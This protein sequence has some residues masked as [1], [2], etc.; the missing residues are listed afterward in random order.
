MG[1]LFKISNTGGDKYKTPNI[2]NCFECCV[3]IS[4]PI[5]SCH[6][7]GLVDHDAPEPWLGG[8]TLE[9]GG[10]CSTFMKLLPEPG[11]GAVHS[12]VGVPISGVRIIDGQHMK[13]GTLNPRQGRMAYYANATEKKILDRSFILEWAVNA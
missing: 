5:S 10:G 11:P 2:L 7:T 9:V 8:R 1:R 13:T 4:E 12:S 6:F 3:I